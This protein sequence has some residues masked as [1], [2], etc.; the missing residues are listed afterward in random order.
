MLVSSVIAQL[1]SFQSMYGDL[2]TALI[3]NEKAEVYFPTVDL[4]KLRK[5]QY[6]WEGQKGLLVPYQQKV[7]AIVATEST[8]FSDVGN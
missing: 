5:F 2:E 3:S 8:K 1:H 6:V 7:I 4:I